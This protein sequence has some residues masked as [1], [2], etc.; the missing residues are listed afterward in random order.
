[1]PLR[2]QLFNMLMPP[3]QAEETHNVFLR[4]VATALSYADANFSSSWKGQNRREQTVKIP[5]MPHM[6]QTT[7]PVY[8]P[9]HQ[10]HM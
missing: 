9:S 2:N 5:A 1:M 3:L 10:I 4:A 8:D 6:K 7:S